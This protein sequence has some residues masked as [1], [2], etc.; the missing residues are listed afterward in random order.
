MINAGRTHRRALGKTNLILLIGLLV[1]TV[2]AEFY[3]MRKQVLRP[4][5]APALPVSAAPS[6]SLTTAGSSA[7]MQTDQEKLRS[8]IKVEVLEEKLPPVILQGKTFTVIVQKFR[9][10]WP[11][12][13]RHTFDPDDDET[14]ISFEIRDPS[15]AVAYA[16]MPNEPVTQ[17]AMLDQARREGRVG[18]SISYSVLR[19]DGL[20]QQALLVDSGELPSA[21]DACDTFWVFGLFA[22]KLKPFA[23]PYCGLLEFPEST[24]TGVV[25]LKK[26]VPP[27]PEGKIV[28]MSGQNRGVESLAQN[29]VFEI[30]YWTGHFNV[31]FPVQVDFAMGRLRPAQ[32]C[33]RMAEADGKS[34]PRYEDLCDFHVKADRVPAAEDTFVRLF[35]EPDEKLT[36]KHVVVKR[37]SKVEFMAVRTT[38]IMDGQ[39]KWS[40][41]FEENP[42]LKVRID[43][44]VGWVR[45]EED[46]EALGLPQAG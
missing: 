18:F 28:D 24:Q 44:Q 9:L 27:A 30:R 3:G 1:T 16:R 46:L 39:G 29:D 45:S 21:P 4:A 42:W 35:P 11:P 36:P 19:L 40:A 14:A 23:E 15:G 5:P 13:A 38:N 32:Q 26:Y 34:M 7:A 37:N 17:Q 10:I 2:L 25:R 43:G 8:Q 12:E 20:L 22:G 6:P 31:L 41:K 33:L